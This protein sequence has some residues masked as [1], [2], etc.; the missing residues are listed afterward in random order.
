MAEV[1]LVNPRRRKR[2][3]TSARRRKTKSHRRSRRTVAAAPR[4]RRRRSVARMSNPHRRHSRRS[5][6]RSV[7]RRRRNPSFRSIAGGAVPT[8]KA[9]FTGALGALG[10]DFLWGY[11]KSYLPASIAG[12]AL[13][14]YAA[15]LV[16]ALLIGFV[17]NK[18]LRGKGQAMAVGAATVVIHDALK[19][20]VQAS[21]PSIPLGAYLSFAPTVGTM[22]RAGPY[23]S[24]GVP[25]QGMGQYLGGLPNTDEDFVYNGDFSG[26]GMNGF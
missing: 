16:G 25:S 9:G 5:L 14:Q 23:L 6:T 12:S 1:L 8:L 4:R 19:A 13:A 7:R 24:T 3:K 22:D 18:V 17:G 26:D 11:G 21:F 20:Q 10:L 15:K 2:R